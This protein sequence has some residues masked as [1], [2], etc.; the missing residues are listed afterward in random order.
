MNQVINGPDPVQQ[1]MDE[2]PS[3]RHLGVGEE[4]SPDLNVG[5]RDYRRQST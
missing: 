3:L 1:E 4:G 5:I 2:A